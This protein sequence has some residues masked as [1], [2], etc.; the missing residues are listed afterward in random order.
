MITRV[1]LTKE[2]F[3]ELVNGRIVRKDFRFGLMEICLSDIGFSVMEE[4][5]SFAQM[6]AW[7]K[8]GG[9]NALRGD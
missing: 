7:A 1:V 5:I 6:E 4:E 9:K 3:I 8:T 2:D